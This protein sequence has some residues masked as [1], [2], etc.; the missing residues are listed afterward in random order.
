MKKIGIETESLHL[1]FQNGRIDL[2]KFIELVAAMEFSGVVINMVAK[3]GQV[4]GLGSL[5]SDDVGYLREIAQ[6]LKQKNL[7]V[8]LDTRGVEFDSLIHIFDIASILGAD[9]IRTF[10][11]SGSGY[12]V[13][14]TGGSFDA[15]EFAAGAGKIKKLLPYLKEKNIRLA[16]EN[17]E[18]ET[19]M[20]IVSLL[21]QVGSPL[22]GANFDFGNSMMAWEEPFKAAENLSCYT[23]TTHIK[24][25]LICFDNSVNGYVVCGA[26]LGD[27]NI[28]IP[29]IA[30][31]LPDTAHFNLEMCHPYAGTFKR[32]KGTGGVFR[33]NEGS[34]LIK[35]APIKYAEP[36]EYYNYQGEHLEE[37]I[38]LQM[39][40]LKRSMTYLKKNFSMK[41]AN[42]L[43][44]R[45]LRCR[46]KH[47]YLG[48]V[49]TFICN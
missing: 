2:P 18:C 10:V 42:R 38:Q 49:C 16:I 3:R 39:T 48:K 17:H 7:Y 4:P 14:N 31:I 41:Y 20:E 33:L 19:S 15:A 8:E 6:I 21:Q 30:K 47:G 28:N 43:C 25:H 13:N 37:L 32:K 34:F 24:D 36:L 27:G 46:R 1:W 22:V 5:G 11:M 35:E 9:I 23:I 40:D 12:S 29:A 45:L 44:F 26:P